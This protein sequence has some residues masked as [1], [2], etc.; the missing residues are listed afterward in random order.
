ML[1]PRHVRAAL[2]RRD[3]IRA[4]RD[5]A[6][7]ELQR[8]AELERARRAGL[9]SLAAYEGGETDAEWLAWERVRNEALA[10][11]ADVAAR[12][13]RAGFDLWAHP[14]GVAWLQTAPS[15]RRD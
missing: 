13:E 9:A 1:D 4:G 14:A 7:L 11:A 6:A 8:A 12:L 5:V 2:A 3:A 10:D 15:V